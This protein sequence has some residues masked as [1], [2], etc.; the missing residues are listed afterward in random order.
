MMEAFCVAPLLRI[1]SA[2]AGRA[3]EFRLAVLTYQSGLIFL[4]RDIF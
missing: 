1:E 3:A 4:D 2:I